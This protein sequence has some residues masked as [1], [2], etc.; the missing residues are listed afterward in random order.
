[1]RAL[2][3]GQDPPPPGDELAKEIGAL[4]ACMAA[5]PD[6][7]RAGLEYVGTLTPAQEILRRP[8]IQTK[9][10]AAMQTFRSAGPPPSM[11]GPN[12]GQLLA[13]IG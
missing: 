2:V 13:L 4:F 7:F 6:L 5:D 8:D 11:P 10:A 1:M 12:R 3:A 9:I